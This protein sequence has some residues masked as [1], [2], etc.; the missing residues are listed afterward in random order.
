MKRL[1]V[2]LVAR[3]D[4]IDAVDYTAREN[5]GAAERLRARLIEAAGRLGTFPAMGRS[6]E[7]GRRL[8]AVPGTPFLLIYREEADHVLILRVWHG[9]RQWPPAG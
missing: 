4:L 3:R 5:R 8:F 6:D 7:M 2:T 9:A 1:R